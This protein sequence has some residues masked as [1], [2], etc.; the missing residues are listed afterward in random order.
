LSANRTEKS[1]SFEAIRSYSAEAADRSQGNTMDVIQESQQAV[2][3]RTATTP[4][5]ESGYAEDRNE[6]ATRTLVDPEPCPVCG[7]AG[8][9]KWLSGPDRLHGRREQYTLVRCAI[10]SVVWLIHPPRPE[11]MHL[12]YTE[13]YDR[14][15]SAGGNSPMRW[16]FRRKAIAEIKQQGALLDLGCSSGA[17]LEYMRGE[18]WKLFGVEMSAR[19]A[20]VAE[21]KSGAQV[22]VGNILDATFAKETF[23]VITCF[24]VLEHLY[25][26]KKVMARVAE[27]L[28]PGGIFYVLVPNVD[29]AEG[30]V[31]G[32]YWHGLELPRHLFHYSPKSLKFLA[33]SVGLDDVSLETH[34]NPAVG[35]S[36]RYI[37]D[38]VFRTVGIRQTPVAHRGEAS[39]PWR[40]AR[41]VVRLTVLRALLAMAPLLGG[42]ESI[43]AIFRKKEETL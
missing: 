19:T 39:L 13:A 11:E 24:D 28:K 12:H 7:H 9:S 31:F 1:R 40:A 43:H 38:D 10:C 3:N 21:A 30:R 23:D 5:G 8:A 22:F 6:G 4:D 42:G 14:L 37:W 41:K 25:E 27:W 16:E 33:E 15:I 26:P 35:T 32:S 17:F 2:D 18:S 36:L 34:R 20:K 29:S